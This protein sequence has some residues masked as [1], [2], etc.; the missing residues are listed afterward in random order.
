MEMEEVKKEQSSLESQLASFKQ[1]IDNL[2]LEVEAQ[3]N[4]VNSAY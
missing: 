1:L 2:I 3:K 4:K